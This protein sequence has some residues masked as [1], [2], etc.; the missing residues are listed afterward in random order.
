MANWSGATVGSDFHGFIASEMNDAITGPFK[1]P[2]FTATTCMPDMGALIGVNENDWLL[3]TDTEDLRDDKFASVGADPFTSTALPSAYAGGTTY[4]AGDV[5]EN[6]GSYYKAIATTAGHGVADAT[7]WEPFHDFVVGNANGVFAYYGKNI[8]SAFAEPAVGS[9]AVSDCLYFKDSYL[10]IAET[11]PMHISG[12]HGL[13]PLHEIG[14]S[15]KPNSVG[16]LWGYAENEDGLVK[17]QYKGSIYG[18]PRV[19]IFLNL[20]GREFKIRLYMVTHT[21]H[22]WQIQEVA[23]GHLQGRG[24]I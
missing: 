19:K 7:K 4:S 16:Y 23:L 11:G 15:F 14:V 12:E 24:S 22:P 8:T 3:W 18:K 2:Q 1:Y 6:S 13:K 5:A 17:G 9:T 20:R 10:S 21:G